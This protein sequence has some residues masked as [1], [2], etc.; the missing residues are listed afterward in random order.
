MKLT[1]YCLH[2]EE[3]WKKAKTKEGRN[4][5]L[6]SMANTLYLLFFV[7]LLVY[8]CPCGCVMHLQSVF[9]FFRMGGFFYANLYCSNSYN[10]LRN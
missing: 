5:P 10:R 9:F 2:L 4:Y 6:K 1:L 7:L 3:K 8:F